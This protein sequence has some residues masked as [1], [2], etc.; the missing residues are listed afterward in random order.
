MKKKKK[1]VLFA[2]SIEN[3]KTLKYHVFSK[4]ALFFS[5]FVIIAAVKI[6]HI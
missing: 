5:L 1:M 6:K 2:V 3:L 4:K